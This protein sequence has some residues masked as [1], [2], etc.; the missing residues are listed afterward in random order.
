VDIPRL[1]PPG[2]TV[3]VG[4]VT[5]EA[6]TRPRDEKRQD[7]GDQTTQQRQPAA[8]DDV[9]LQPVVHSKKPTPDR[10][11]TPASRAARAKQAQITIRLSPENE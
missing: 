11:A 4:P 2:R 9:V 6:H 10:R 1:P 5:N 3:A 8:V 7:E